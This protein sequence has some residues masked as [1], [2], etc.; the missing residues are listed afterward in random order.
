MLDFSTLI[1][2]VVNHSNPMLHNSTMSDHGH[3][4]S[5]SKFTISSEA[6]VHCGDNHAE[7]IVDATSLLSKQGSVGSVER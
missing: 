5:Y 6:K 3:R 2:S 4:A 7:K 1:T